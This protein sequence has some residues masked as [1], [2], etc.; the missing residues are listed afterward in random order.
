MPNSSFFSTV[1]NKTGNSTD[2]DIQFDSNF[3]FLMFSLI[4]AMTW[5]LYITYY[6]SRVV[7]YF[8][9]RLLTRFYVKKGYLSIGSFTV[10]ALSDFRLSVMLNGYELHI[11]NRCKVYSRLEQVFGLD[12]VIIPPNEMEPED[13]LVEK[14][15]P[16]SL[17]KSWRDLI[18]VIKVD[19][20]SGRVVFGNRLVPTTLSINVEEAHFMY[21]TKPAASKLDHFMHFV[22]CKAENFKVILAP[23]PKYMGISDEPPRYMGAGFVVLSSNNMDLY[24]YM[25]EPGLVP[26]EPHMLELANGEMVES[27]APMWGVD[28]KCGKGTDFSYGPWADRQ[29]EHLFKFFFPQDCQTM[30]PTPAPQPGERRSVQSFDVRL[31]TLH[32]STIDLLFSKNKETNA[33]HVN[34]GQGSYL[35]MTLPWIIGSDGYTTKVT[36]Q[37]LHFEATT[38]LTFRSLVESETLEFAIRSHYPLRWNDHQEWLL[39]LTG[40]KASGYFIYAHKDFFQGTLNDGTLKYVERCEKPSFMICLYGVEYI[41]VWS[42]FSTKFLAWPLHTFS[43]DRENIR[44]DCWSIPI[45]AISINWIYHPMPAFGPPPQADITTPE[46]E[47][48]LLSPMRIPR[49]RKAT[50]FTWPQDGNPK[51]DPTTLPADKVSLEL[52]IGPSVMYLYGSWL[53]N[54]YFLKES[55]FGEDQQFTDMNST[56]TPRDSATAASNPTNAKPNHTTSA[57]ADSNID[58]SCGE[59]EIS[60]KKEFDPRVYRPLDVIVSITMHDI[61]AHLMKNCTDNDPACPVILIERFGFEMKKSYKETLLQLLLSPAI[62]ITTDRVLNRTSKDKHL[63]Q[64]HLMLSGLQIRGHAMFSDT[65]RSLDQETLEYAWQLEIQL[66]KLSGKFTSPQLYHVITGLETLV[67][68]ITDPESKLQAPRLP[69]ECHHGIPPLTC[70]ESD[71]DGKYRGPPSCREMTG[72]TGDSTASPSPA[73]SVERRPTLPR[74]FSYNN[75][76]LRTI[77]GVPYA[78]LIDSSPTGEYITV[79][80]R[81]SYN[82]ASLRT[83]N[84]VPYARLI[85]SSPTG[86]YIT[87]ETRPI[88]AP[89]GVGGGVNTS[90]GGG[91]SSNTNTSGSNRSQTSLFTIIPNTCFSLVLQATNSST[92]GGVGGGVNTSGGGGGSSSNTNTSGSNRSQT[93]G[94]DVNDLWLEIASISGGPLMLESVSSMCETDKSLHLVQAKYLK[95]PGFGQSILH[96]SQLV[97]HTPPYNAP[98]VAIHDYPPPSWGDNKP[99]PPP[100]SAPPPNQ[101]TGESYL[102]TLPHRLDSDSRLHTARSILSVPESNEA[103][104]PPKSSVSD[105]RLAV[106][107]FVAPAPNLGSGTDDIPAASESEQSLYNSGGEVRYPRTVSLCSENQSDVFF[108]A[109]EE[110]SHQLASTASATDHPSRSG[111]SPTKLNSVQPRCSVAVP[112]SATIGNLELGATRQ[113]LYRSD[114]EIH[115]PE[116]RDEM[117][118][119]EDTP[120][121]APPRIPDLGS[122]DW[123]HH[124]GSLLSNGSQTSIFRG[125]SDLGSEDWHH[126]RGSLLS[127]VMPRSVS[128]RLLASSLNGLAEADPLLM[129]SSDSISSTSFISAVSSQE[130]LA[131][132]NLHMQVN[133]PIIDS[134]LL[135][136]TYINHLSQISCSN[137]TQVSLPAGSDAFTVPLFQRS[138]DGRLVFI[139]SKYLPKFDTITEGFTCLK[140]VTRSSPGMGTNKDKEASSATRTPTCAYPWDSQVEHC[141]KKLEEIEANS[142][143][144]PQ[145]ELLSMRNECGTKTTVVVKMKGKFIDEYVSGGSAV[146]GSGEVGGTSGCQEKEDSWASLSEDKMGFIMME[147]GLEG[148]GSKRSTAERKSKPGD[149]VPCHTYEETIASQV[150]GSIVLPKIN[151]AVLQVSVV[152]EV[153]AFSALDNIRDLTCVSFLAICLEGITT[154]FHIGKESREIVQTFHRPTVTPS[155][156]KNNVFKAAHKAFLLGHSSSNN[157]GQDNKVGEPVYIE[158]SERT[159]EETVIT[160]HVSRLHMQL[161]R[162]QN[163][164]SLLQVTGAL[165]PYPRILHLNYKNQSSDGRLVFIGSKYLPKFDTI[166]EGFTCLKMVT[167]SSPGMGTNKDKEGVI[168]LSRQWKNILYTP[169]LLEHNFKI[170]NH[171]MKPMN[172]TFAIPDPEEV[173]S[174][175]YHLLNERR[176]T[177]IKSTLD[178]SL[179]ASPLLVDQLPN[180]IAALQVEL[181]LRSRILVGQLQ[182]TLLANQILVVLPQLITPHQT[183]STAPKPNP[184]TP[185]STKSTAANTTKPNATATTTSKSNS[186]GTTSVTTKPNDTTI[187]TSKPTGTAVVSAKPNTTVVTSSKPAVS[188]SAGKPNSSS[189][190]GTTAT[191]PNS[192]GST[193]ANTTGK[194]NSGSSSAANNTNKPNSGSSSAAHSTAKPN[195][196]VSGG[197]AVSGSGEV[198]GT[199]GCQEKEDSWASLA[200]DKMGFIMMECGLEGVS[201]KVVKRSKFERE[202]DSNDSKDKTEIVAETTGDSKIARDD[203]S[204]ETINISHV[205]PEEVTSSSTPKGSR[206]PAPAP[207]ANGTGN[208]DT[209]E[210]ATQPTPGGDTSKALVPLIDANASSC[211][212]DVKS[213]WFNFAAPPRYDETT[214]LGNLRE[215]AITYENMTDDPDDV[216]PDTE[217][218]DE[219]AMLLQSQFKPPHEHAITYEN[220]TDDPDDVDPDTEVTDECAMLLQSQFKPPHDLESTRLLDAH[221]IFEPLLASLGVM[222]QQVTMPLLRLLHQISNMYTNVKVTQSELRDQVAPPLAKSPAPPPLGLGR[223]PPELFDKHKAL[224]QADVKPV[225]SPSASVRSKHQSFV[226]KLRSTSKSVRGYMNL[227]DPPRDILPGILSGTAPLPLTEGRDSPSKQKPDDLPPLSTPRCWKTVY[228]LLDLYATMPETKTV[229]HRISM[230]AADV[231]DNFKPSQNQSANTSAKK[232]D[233]IDLEKGEGVHIPPPSTPTPIPAGPPQYSG[234]VSHCVFSG[235]KQLSSTLQELRVTRTSS[236]MSRGTTVDDVDSVPS[237]LGRDPPNTSPPHPR[238]PPPRP[239]PPMVNTTEV[240]SNNL[241]TNTATNPLLSP[242]VMHFTG[243]IQ[244]VTFT[245]A[246]LPSL[247]AQYRMDQLTSAGVTGSKAKFVIDLPRHS[248]SFSTKV[249]VTEANLPSEASIDLPKIHVSAEYIQDGGNRPGD[250]PPT[251]GVTYRQGSY[252]SAVADIGIFEHSLTTDLLNHLVFVQKV[253]MK[254]VNEVSHT[255]KVAT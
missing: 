184:G 141:V 148:G 6:N 113:P 30:V 204:S 48:I 64:G 214:E 56:T 71:A 18:P 224:V 231:S 25:D 137:W 34:V 160:L 114:H 168:V 69:P 115:T 94:N 116:H 251:E 167:R 29:R 52:E 84:G 107:Y 193:T 169:L 215:H 40:C 249:Q 129:D 195:S 131:L 86:E 234:P 197:S 27:A 4:L 13:D 132:V 109:E 246:L 154:R 120:L 145:E 33:V 53:R 37:L 77:N 236:R 198:G 153:I 1:S 213:V 42:G 67:L 128:P 88:A 227:G 63:Q 164:S 102:G 20:S 179:L 7:G 185:N 207:G 85:D 55:I 191:K 173:P 180:R 252:M 127:N 150:Q 14:E 187:T 217:V 208:G 238:E 228:Y 188:G 242:F 230:G 255:G 171:P 74:R 243:L 60:L 66:G 135:M 31:S 15:E 157:T 237:G 22:K 11:Y 19:V 136:A 133:K 75:A 2:L 99:P 209:T 161:R 149:Q 9:T 147:C 61:Q 70:P 35:E 250:I 192:S 126:H 119:L 189:T 218:T 100:P 81:F 121:T 76:S 68:L 225:V 108:S 140:M 92:G 103:G 174:G 216:D 155:G 226:Q 112:S 201:F 211:V 36:G 111:M 104:L 239:P 139:G 43:F 57:P 130:D 151:I 41:K 97:F 39:N 83:I 93:R 51:F 183:S 26:R 253:F 80:T 24:F 28:I 101:L 244:S 125:T 65:G 142:K 78:R 54:F 199:S 96:E 105:S 222:P 223:L 12:P 8:I 158:T 166:T 219:C 91:S 106:D 205:K 162:L 32:E 124:R 45:A 44:I 46:K 200:E 90:G 146:S 163:Q 186:A 17:G 16:P 110:L 235:S 172:V 144:G 87:V 245:A 23:S 134:P 21:S 177:Q 5:V 233:D 38:S 47:E 72:S 138:S 79:E 248:L 152:E 175:V 159:Q 176:T 229:A 178:S 232:P 95:D 212:I 196:N 240:M 143:Q 203:V 194:P 170:K 118:L 156:K 98:D 241:S 254:E 202:E 10:C 73:S 206:T 123:H 221:L 59:D 210:S 220:M 62:L 190:S 3:A 247:Q 58:T 50:G 49:S 82:N 122:E 117:R 181:R 89:G 165:P 182:L